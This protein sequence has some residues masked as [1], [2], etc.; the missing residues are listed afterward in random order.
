M[1]IVLTEISPEERSKQ[2]ISAPTEQQGK[3]PKR[4]S[5][6]A[7]EAKQAFKEW[8]K[9]QPIPQV[10]KNPDVR[11]KAVTPSAANVEKLAAVTESETAPQE[12]LKQE[13][14]EG[15]FFGTLFSS[16]T[17][18]EYIRMQGELQKR[19]TNPKTAK[20]ADADWAKV[21][22][23]F[24]AA[25]DAAGM[26][27]TSDQLATFAKDL[28]GNK[29]NL[30]AVAGIANSRVIKNPPPAAGLTSADARD[31]GTLTATFDTTLAKIIDPNLLTIVIPNLCSQ[32]FAQGSITRHWSHSWSLTASLPYPCPTWTNPFRICWSTVTVATVTVDIGLTVGY[33]VSCCGASAFG[34]AFAQACGS[35]LGVTKCVGCTATVVGVAG[36]SR[37]PFGTQ[38]NY[39]LGINASISCQVFGAT[40]FS[41]SW[42]FGYTVTGPCPPAGLC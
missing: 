6:S 42:P 38:C 41:A 1:A 18:F 12:L 13:L 32:P 20:T 26:K 40:V 36:F 35:V 24:Q 7:T 10:G 23:G 5:A 29:R 9:Q 30:D 39:G 33:K 15:Q 31:A 37:T 2:K 14:D 21:V 19:K 4:A 34:Q 17:T 11:L 28:A 22:Q 3:F 8:Q 27:V 16:L 25:Y